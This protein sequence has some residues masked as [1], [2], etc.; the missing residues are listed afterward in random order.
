MKNQWANYQAKE[1]AGDLQSYEHL[2]GEVLQGT[3][4]SWNQYS[5]TLDTCA[6]MECALSQ[7]LYLM[8]EAWD[9]GM[10]REWKHGMGILNTVIL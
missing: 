9:V 5:L 6:Q 7:M 8:G 2:Y 4:L 3:N 10:F 1:R